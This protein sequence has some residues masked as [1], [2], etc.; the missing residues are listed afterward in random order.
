[1]GVSFLP[2]CCQY[3]KSANTS[4]QGEFVCI[5]VNVGSVVCNNTE[6]P[7]VKATT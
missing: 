1:M 5:A 4:C 6:I 2:K 3:R 7:E